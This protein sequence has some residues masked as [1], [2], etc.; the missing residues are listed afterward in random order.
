MILY[1]NSK[2]ANYIQVSLHFIWRVE[3][4]EEKEEGEEEEVREDE[5]EEEEGK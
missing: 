5:E 3:W 4:G 1:F 2:I